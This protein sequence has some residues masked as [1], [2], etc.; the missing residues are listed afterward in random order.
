MIIS[1]TDKS[2]G[3]LTLLC[4]LAMAGMAM[5]QGTITRVPHLDDGNGSV[6]ALNNAGAVTGSFLAPSGQLH[7]FLFSGGVFQDL[8]TLGGR[9]SEGTALNDFDVVAG[10]ADQPDEDDPQHA[11]VFRNGTMSDLSGLAVDQFSSAR[12]INNAG[13][14]AGETLWSSPFP[15]APR[16][17][18][19]RNGQMTDIGSLGGGLSTILD[20]NESGH[21]VG[22]SADA[23]FNNVAFLYDGTTMHNLGTP[24]GM[25][26]LATAI[27][28]SGVIVGEIAFDQNVTR[29]FVYRDGVMTDLGTLGG[30]SS[31]AR[32]VNNAGQIFGYS[33]YQIDDLAT[34][35]FI[36][37]NGV[38]I[39]LGT[40]GG[41]VSFPFAMNSQGHVIGDSEDHL[42]SAA[43]FLY[44]DGQMV[45]VNSLLPPDSGW[46]IEAALYINDAGQIA[47]FG[48][49]NGELAWY[50]LTP[51]NDNTNS[52]P[53]AHAG[54]D[55]TAQCGSSV[56]L[57]GSGSS[58]PDFD[59]LTYQWRNGETVL[60]TSAI[61]H[62]TLPRG[63]HT[64]TLVVT[65][66]R[67]ATDDDTVRITVNDTTPPRVACPVSQT[68]PVGADCQALVPDFATVAVAIDSCSSVLTRSQTPAAG[69]ALGLGSH[70]VT[71]SV[72]DEAGNVGTCAVTLTV[73]DSTAPVG[74]CP[75][76]R[77]V[78]GCS[79][80]VP[81]FT[82]DLLAT[83]NCTPAGALVKTQSPAAGTRVNSGTHVINL[84]VADAAGN[85]SACSTTFT[86]AGGGNDGPS[87]TGPASAT[88]EAGSD[89]RAAV[90]DFTSVVTV[91]EGC[92]GPITIRQFPHAGKWVRPGEHT[93]TVRVR[94]AAGNV[95]THTVL[96][97][98]VDGTAPGI[99]S[100]RVDPG[101]IK[102]NDG[103]LVRFKVRVR[104]NDNC[105]RAPKS[106]IVSITSSEPIT[107]GGDNTSPDCLIMD[108]LRGRV[109]A[110]TCTATTRLYT[111]T[112]AC[113]DR[114][115]NVA[116]GKT[117]ITVVKK[118]KG[119]ND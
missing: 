14:I 30:E 76:A 16:A 56:Q 85:S 20:L 66:P 62:V 74:D 42:N 21:A 97:N 7:A 38:M 69:V 99:K 106:R 23:L 113:T 2:I 12:F 61:L 90:P 92:N 95:A 22:H 103:D 27:N 33:E 41:T 70:T 115:G 26:S 108:D 54:D 53:E 43:P 88:V 10:N 45:N 19:Y 73:I 15:G 112:V 8:G 63:A 35:A 13:D 104:A 25:G 17:F 77:S 116:E 36:I 40:L 57:D 65:D 49:H 100:I 18:I 52:P 93:V 94:D 46:E 110:E 79:A 6:H 81:D 5:G 11:F 64:L 72:T 109:R 101:V 55:Q 24:G 105:D 80:L 37:D 84:T 98:V 91:V 31:W 51:G 1:R 75:P 114:S 47:G 9:F 82:A 87:V 3:T 86:V 117:T 50:I 71:V 96:L 83:D 89:G 59:L 4:W 44:R 102:D 118:H 68:V 60:G 111:I 78:N 39:D 48:S 58:D 34:H 28:D 67:G 119:K 29:A 107:G 32:G